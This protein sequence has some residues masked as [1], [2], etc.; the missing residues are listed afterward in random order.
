MKIP[1]ASVEL[2]KSK[3]IKVLVV[4]CREQDRE[5]TGRFLSAWNFEPLPAAS[6]AEAV[7]AA[8][9]SAP[10]IAVIA[11]RRG[12]ATGID[13]ARELRRRRP[14]LETILL[15][16][17]GE[18]SEY[19]TEAFRAGVYHCLRLPLDFR[20]L[21]RDLNLLRESMQR[22][23]ERQGWERVAAAGL[24][25]L[26][27]GS[28]PMQG[29]FASIR[30]CALED[31][32]VLI[33]GLI[34]TGKEL[35]AITLH[36]LGARAE[37]PLV[38]YRC[39][40]VS[41]KQA[42]QELFGVPG[43]PTPRATADLMSLP[44]PIDAGILECARGGTLLL[45][46]VADLP[47]SI[48]ARLAEMIPGYLRPAGDSPV[49]AEGFRL[50]A[51]SRLNLTDEAGQ[52]H[53]DAGLYRL[54]SSNIVHLPSLAERQADIPLLC[55]HFQ[56]RF[57][58]EYAKKTSGFSPAAERALMACPWPGNVRELENV[59]DRA[60]LLADQDR[61]DVSDLSI[62]H[63]ADG[64]LRS[65]I[66]ARLGTPEPP[67]FEGEQRRFLSPDATSSKPKRGGGP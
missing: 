20:E 53:F 51:T 43:R 13:L 50:L 38:I 54:L 48:Q 62:A 39:C 66:L 6:G 42:A 55:L 40:G 16:E 3:P 23:A 59:I 5:T 14:A 30:R 22:R 24:D 45:D 19:H 67:Y 17:N 34:G 57:N 41:E 33:T 65:A 52:G 2:M 11:D 7:A 28:A 1:G 58:H 46:E 4:E 56:E 63:G 18:S 32:P 64:V 10:A 61:I 26:V 29:V 8:Q 36:R 44:L 25:G 12:T 49:A 47:A 9:Q 35:A 37:V 21:R 31:S 60:C 15:S 27:G